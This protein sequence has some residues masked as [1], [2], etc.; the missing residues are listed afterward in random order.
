MTRYTLIKD[1]RLCA[2]DGKM[3]RYD[4]LLSG[5]EGAYKIEK[6]TDPSVIRADRAK[7]VNAAGNIALP[8]FVDICP[9]F[10]EP[11]FVYREDISSLT[12]AASAGG[13]CAL[14]GLPLTDPPCD[15][16]ETVYKINDIIKDKAVC[17]MRPVG[18]ITAIS[19]SEILT[20]IPDMV[21]AGVTS[22][23]EGIN[24][25]MSLY[26]KRKV[27]NE[28]RKSGA[29]YISF[30]RINELIR[31][32]KVNEGRVSRLL[33]VDGIPPSAEAVA[34]AS[35]VILSADT[36]CRLHIMN[37]ST[38]AGA[39]IIRSAKKKSIPVTAST[40]PEYISMTEDDVLYHGKSA[41]IYPPLRT[42]SDRR[43][44]C[45]GLIDGTIDCISCNHRPL[46]ANEKDP[47]GSFENTEFGAI[48]LQTAFSAVLE[49]LCYKQKK[50]LS[51]IIDLLSRNP[52]KLF[53]IDTEIREGNMA[54]F[55]IVDPSEEYVV[56]KNMI[57]S[58][59]GSTPFEGMTMR[60]TV[61]YNYF[62]YL[63]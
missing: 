43:A 18:K 9:V 57:L 5:S 35:D 24:P 44:V 55:C 61:K 16:P 11:G 15:T 20:N 42:E 48:G 58:R 21:S 4:I 3:S 32:G 59:S 14:L 26:L 6:I 12:H 47:D 1:V 27:M 23:T 56:S 53:G 31:R 38:A 37:V 39:E 8:A 60:G 40:A 30:P 34:I 19:E 50:P 22:F 28:C 17:A 10:C 51:L 63:P 29:V 49:Q 13:F 25:V 7:I 54:N 52:A 36:G 62:S 46:R 41:F 33:K 2:G 45:L